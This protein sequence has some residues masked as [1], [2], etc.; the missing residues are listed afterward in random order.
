MKRLGGAGL[1]RT[2]LAFG[3]VLWDLLPTGALLGGAPF[4]FVYRV[5]SLGHR[6]LMISR[7]GEDELG[8]KALRIIEALGMDGTYIQSDPSHHTGTVDVRF[9]ELKNPDFTIVKNAAYDFIEPTEAVRRLAAGADCLCFGTLIQ[10]S[11]VS[12][13]TLWELLEAFRGRYALLDINLRRDCYT[14]DTVRSSVA[15]ASILKCNDGEA[16]SLA[17]MFGLDGGSLPRLA[18]GLFRVSKLE[19]VV[20][21]LGEKGAFAADREGEMVYHPGFAVRLVDSLGSGDAFAAGFIHSLLAGAPLA[22]ACIHGNALGALV[23][24]QEGATQP[25]EDNAIVSFLRRRP[26]AGPVEDSL[27]EYRVE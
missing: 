24:E 3:E 22:E 2:V 12:R 10:R 19:H 13:R 20:V 15:R 7:L 5:N 23:A 25:L 6:G 4:N 14:D 17:Q 9:D 27:E 26:P 18:Q 21:T 8:G 11:E 1:R 16:R